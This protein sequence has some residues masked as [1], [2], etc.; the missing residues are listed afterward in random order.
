MT[1]EEIRT[2]V[3]CWVESV[4]RHDVRGVMTTYADECVL[5]SPIYGTLIGRDAIE[6]SFELYWATFPD[7]DT[8]FDDPLIMG[9]GAV[10]TGTFHGTDT[11]GFLGQAPTGKPFRV[12]LVI[13]FTVNNRR[14][15]REQRIYDVS[16]WLLQLAGE[17]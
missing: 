17:I 7:L 10:V 16:G 3:A 6:K 5:E 2:L 4:N 8:K 15:V 1:D 12:F 9:N 14:I 13:L 11:G